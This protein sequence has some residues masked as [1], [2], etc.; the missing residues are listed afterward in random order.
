[1]S[2]GQRNTP[3]APTYLNSTPLVRLS[4]LVSDWALPTTQEPGPDTAEIA[5]KP[6]DNERSGGMA[7]LLS[8]VYMNQPF[9][10]CMRLLRQEIDCPL[11]LA[12]PSNGRSIAA[13]MAI[14]AMTTRS[15]INV[16]AFVWPVRR[17]TSR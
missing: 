10:S 12:L 6:P 9:W 11:A 8:W 13:R 7:S 16:K 1:L 2:V 17:V 15:S 14:I 4:V 3:T 5:P